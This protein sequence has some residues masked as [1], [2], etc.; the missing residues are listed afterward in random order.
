MARKRCHVVKC[1]KRGHFAKVCPSVPEKVAAIAAGNPDEQEEINVHEDEYHD[2]GFFLGEIGN[3]GK[4]MKPWSE[5]VKVNGVTFKFKLDGVAD[6]TVI[7]GSIHSRLFSKPKLEE[8]RKKSYL[9]HAK[10]N[11]TVWVYFE[12]NC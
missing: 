6:V 2:E 12:R 8:T 11:L 4:K 5:E 9:G 1:C 3:I 7:A 10:V